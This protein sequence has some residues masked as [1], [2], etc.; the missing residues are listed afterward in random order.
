[1][2]SQAEANRSSG[3]LNMTNF[4]VDEIT[5]YRNMVLISEFVHG[6]S[7]LRIGIQ[8]KFP[9]AELVNEADL[10]EEIENVAAG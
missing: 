5:L 2:K 8:L 1:M 4:V 9:C 7:S 10:I 6:A 3:S